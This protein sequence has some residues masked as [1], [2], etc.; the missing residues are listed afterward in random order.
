MQGFA[1]WHLEATSLLLWQQH[2]W[3]ATLLVSSS[4]LCN[5]L[6]HKILIAF[7]AWKALPCP[8]FQRVWQPGRHHWIRALPGQVCS[9]LPDSFLCHF[10]FCSS[11][12]RRISLIPV[13][14]TSCQQMARKTDGRMDRWGQGNWT[15]FNHEI[16]RQEVH[17]CVWL[18]DI[19][20]APGILVWKITVRHQLV[21]T[22]EIG[23]QDNNSHHYFHDWRFYGVAGTAGCWEYF[24]YNCLSTLCSFKALDLLNFGIYL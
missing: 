16:R 24:N 3:V 11:C 10:G 12:N 20:R 4:I 2:G 8:W 6:F 9:S 14:I 18:V 15:P 5:L 21:Y 22:A 17:L 1:S 13:Y 19:C 23:I 7:R